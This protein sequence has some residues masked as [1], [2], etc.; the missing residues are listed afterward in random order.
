MFNE[1]ESL[2]YDGHRWKMTNEY[3][4]KLSRRLEKYSAVFSEFWEIGAPV[5]LESAPVVEDSGSDDDSK[6]DSKKA[7]KGKPKIDPQPFRAAVGF[8]TEGNCITF[9]FGVDYWNSLTEYDRLFII[10]HEMLHVIL[11]HGKRF[12]TREEG[13]EGQNVRANK[14]MDITIN[15]M[16]DEGF[17]ISRKKCSSSIKDESCWVDTCFGVRRYPDGRVEQVPKEKV[18]P[19][20]KNFEYYYNLLP[21]QKVI[22]INMSMNGGKGGESGKS[23]DDHKHYQISGKNADEIIDKLDGELSDEAK[24][25]L[26]EVLEKLDPDL[27]ENSQEAGAEV[28]GKWHV[29]KK[30]KVKKKKKWETVIKEWT[31]KKINKEFTYVENWVRE[32]KRLGAMG[33]LG[34]ILPSSSLMENNVVEKEKVEVWFYQDTSG[35]CVSYADRF[36]NAAM[37]IPH[38]EDDPFIIRL[39]CFDTQVYDV[40]EKTRELRVFGG[41]SFSILEDHLQKTMKKEKIKRHPT[42]FVITDG[43]GDLISPEKPKLWH[44]FMTDH[45]STNCIPNDCHVFNLKDYE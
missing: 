34:V 4:F 5:F 19:T 10:A 18:P 25:E 33:D 32:H 21:E 11:K 41:T 3:F 9:M 13:N 20:G 15:H 35:S 37:T 22:Y 16:I 36:F 28:G 42:V 26:K 30:K 39:F 43:Y 7:K 31:N 1:D 17:R 23:P 27:I 40:D 24:E 12:R 44:W 8:D 6:D 14:A 38:G 29:V 45:Y 2:Q